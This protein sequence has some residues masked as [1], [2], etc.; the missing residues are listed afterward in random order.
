MALHSRSSLSSTNIN[1]TTKLYNKLACQAQ[2]LYNQ[3]NGMFTTLL[4][5]N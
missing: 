2:M 1:H 5:N 4:I 3:T